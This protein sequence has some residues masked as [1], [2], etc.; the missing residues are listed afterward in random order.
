MKLK[1]LLLMLL[2][3]CSKQDFENDIAVPKILKDYHQEQ[4]AK[5]G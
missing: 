4:K 5:K 3:A 1:F 2:I